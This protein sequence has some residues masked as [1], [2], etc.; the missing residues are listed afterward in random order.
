[1]DIDDIKAELDQRV[2]LPG[3]TNAWV[4]PIKT[5]I[6]MLATGI[7]TPV[8]IKVAGPDLTVIQQIGEDIESVLKNLPATASVYSERVGGGRYVTVDIRRQQASRYGLNI[9]DVQD[10]VRSAIGGMDI[11][12]TV[13]GPER[14]PVNLRY[15]R[16]VRDSVQQLR[17]LVVV[18]PAGHQIP[19]SAVADIRVED[20]PPMIKSENARLNGWV[21]VD[22]ESKDLGGYVKR[23]RQAVAD[24]VDLPPGYS[25]SWSGQY[26]YMERARERLAV[27]VPITLLIIVLLLFLNFRSTAEVLIIITTL[28]LSVVGGL[29]LLYLLDYQVSVA[30]G[31][32][33][34]ALAG[35]A[36]EIG[37]L[38]LVYL[39]QAL[40]N[41]KHKARQ[42]RRRLSRKDLAAAVE[43][44]ALKRVRP[45][46]MTVATIIVGLLPIMLGGGTGSEV[47]QRIAAP[48]VGGMVSATALALV[49]IPAVF[50]LWQQRL[51]GS[52][53]T[54]QADE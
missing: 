32:G 40:A 8:G 35:V 53:A 34:I 30:V 22:I 50:L 43:N 19:L 6:D 3:L 10:V 13:E 41:E 24:N 2:R 46:M 37:V 27:V 38:M 28:P 4:W 39:N 26:E 33:F 29:W 54:E 36:V 20:G 42:E 9:D 45:V 49:A 44:G 15:P 51:L 7:K 48:M 25:L 1:M 52:Q 31:V 16:E 18:T 12:E 11:T 47:M 14:Y 17:D 21:L 5:R 23:A